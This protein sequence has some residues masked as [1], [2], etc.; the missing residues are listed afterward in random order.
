MG[1]KLRLVNNDKIGIHRRINTF[2]KNYFEKELK[3]KREYLTL[4]HY[5]LA[6]ELSIPVDGD[7]FS[8][9]YIKSYRT[10]QGVLHNP[11]NDRRTTKGSFQ[12]VEGGLDIPSDKKVVPKNVFENLYEAAINPP[13]ELELIPFTANQEEKARS[14]VSLLVKPLVSPKVPGITSKKNMEI[15]FLAPGSLVSNLDFV[16]SVFGNAGDPSYH[17]NDSGLDVNHWSGHTGHIVLAPHLSKLKK[18]DVGLPHY[19]QATPKQR[20]DGMCYVEEDELYNEGL[21]FKLTCRD[22]S[23]VAVTIIGD[24]YF[25]YSKKEIKTM[26]GF[27]ANLYGNVE[28]EHAGGTIVFPRYGLGEYYK[29]EKNIDP[30]KFNFEEVKEKFGSIMDIQEEKL[31]N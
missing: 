18:K 2:F 31:W 7:E 20:K 16:E 28:E 27:A 6:R 21:P 19:D 23:G 5:G 17:K 9:N 10:K 24:N 14:F 8:N 12:I 29:A 13:G 22:K 1:K 3:V 4:D 11:R 15:L 25:G 26:I 30:N